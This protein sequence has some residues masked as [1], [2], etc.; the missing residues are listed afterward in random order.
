[1]F[2]VTADDEFVP[3]DDDDGDYDDTAMVDA[4]EEEPD[5]NIVDVSAASF[6]QHSDSVYCAAFH[7][8]EAGMMVS[9]GGDDRAFMWRYDTGASQPDVVSTDT[10]GHETAGTD[11]RALTS[12][13]ITWSRELG[14]HT[15]TVTAVSFNFDGTLLL[16]GGYD[17]KVN[18]WTVATGELLFAL[19]G[20][21][22]VEFA[23]WHSKGNAV[24]AGS[25]DGTIWMWLAQTGQCVQ[26]TRAM[27]HA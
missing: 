19:E 11:L 6:S 23:C 26:V 2:V 5:L 25:K 13:N 7:P 10:D 15:D 8:T 14:G 24:L 18:I 12:R 17:G 4:E 9:G 21:E 16:T 27:I 22:D 20:P 1:V 3:D